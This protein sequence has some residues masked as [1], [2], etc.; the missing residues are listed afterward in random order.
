MVF[1]KYEIYDYVLRKVFLLTNDKIHKEKP[2]PVSFLIELQAQAYN[3]IKRE[4]LARVV[5]SPDTFAPRPS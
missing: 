4:T 5:Y 3:F 2:V 1:M